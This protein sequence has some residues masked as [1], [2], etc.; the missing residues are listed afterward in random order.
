MP[1]APEDLREFHSLVKIV[2]ALRGPDGCPWDK[3]QTHQSLTRHAI[4][5]VYEMI[6]AIE[7]E[8][9]KELA[10]ELGDVLLQ[11]VLHA[12]IAREEGSFDITDVIATI[13]EKMVRRHPHVFGQTKVKDSQEVLKNWDQI[14]EQEK[15]NAPS[16]G[17]NVPSYL[18]AL[19]ASHKIGEKSARVRFDWDHPHEVLAKVEE[20]LQE[21]KEAMATGNQSHIEHEVGDLLFS[22]VQL[23][24][25]LNVDSEKA[26]RGCNHRFEQR[27]IRMKQLI[28]SDGRHYDDLSQSELEDYYTRAKAM[29]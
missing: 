4:E 24:R 23:A 22:T 19:L 13:G 17:F 15:K 2:R 20:E 26:L 18:P 5:E 10:E 7:K 25:H 16:P 6:H 3:E 14:K 29:E 9:Q 1:Q 27:F 28:Q 21:L 11:V 12:E 8:D